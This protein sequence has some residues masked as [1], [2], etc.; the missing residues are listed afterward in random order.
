MVRTVKAML[1]SVVNYQQKNWTEQLAAIDFAYNNA[2]HPSTQLTP[3]ELDIGLHP[4]TPYTCLFPEVEVPSSSDFIDRLE[5]LP[6]QALEYLEKTGQKQS[7]QVNKSRPRPQK[8][9][10][11]D[12]ARLSK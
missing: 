6:N 1:R 11:R 9:N 3:F 7:E 4:R 10:V 12:I 2:V 5:A 8:F